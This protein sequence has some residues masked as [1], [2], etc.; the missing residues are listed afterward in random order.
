MIYIGFISW[1][2]T[3]YSTRGF[4]L[5]LPSLS[6]KLP[7]FYLKADSFLS[8]CDKPA[9]SSFT[10]SCSTTYNLKNWKNAVN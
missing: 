6:I 3:E 5:I 9:D 4:S 1:L 8:F 10:V 2:G 7:V